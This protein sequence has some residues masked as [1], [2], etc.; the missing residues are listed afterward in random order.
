MVV[1]PIRIQM[2]GM[3]ARPVA[4]GAFPALRMTLPCSLVERCTSIQDVLIEIGM[5]LGRRDESDRA[6]T[7]LVVIP[8]HQSGD[9]DTRCGQGVERL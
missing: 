2:H 6:V 3:Y 9:P 4:R 7:M 5:A 8:T 1:V